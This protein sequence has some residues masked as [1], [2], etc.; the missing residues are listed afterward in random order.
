MSSPIDE[1]FT[2]QNLKPGT[3]FE[4]GCSPGQFTQRTAARP[5][6]QVTAIDLYLPEVEGFEFIHGDFMDVEI[7]RQFDNVCCVSSFEHCGIE[8]VNYVGSDRYQEGST[9]DF[10][11]HKPI[12]KKLISLV[13]PGGRFII[14]CP[15][16]PNEIWLINQFDDKKNMFSP[17][18]ISEDK[19]P[20]WGHRTFTLARLKELFAPMEVV[21]ASAF[22]KHGTDHFVLEHWH[23]V[24]VETDHE[25]FTEEKAND[26]IICVVF[27]KNMEQE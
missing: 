13:R 2:E 25:E 26:G 18:E 7:D 1:T 27:E 12:A 3:V 11:Y 6:F 16:G 22:G 19:V 21:K 17:S 4:F 20:K 8:P 10:E 9:P 5:G 23:R 14:T 24:D 15:F